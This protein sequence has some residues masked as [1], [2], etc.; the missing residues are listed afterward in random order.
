[1]HDDPLAAGREFVVDGEWTEIEADEG[2]LRQALVNL[3]RNALEAAGPGG[4]VGVRGSLH[5]DPSEFLLEVHDSGPGLAE[6]V[7]AADLFRPFF[8]TKATGIGLGLAWVR[9][10]VVY[11]DG[12]VD[13]GRGPWGGASFRMVLPLR[14]AA[15][16]LLPRPRPT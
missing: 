16:N 7:S 11:H 6:G 2:L 9:K 14:R 10:S 4:R 8:T 1:M 12:R 15:E 5:R 3:L 13:V